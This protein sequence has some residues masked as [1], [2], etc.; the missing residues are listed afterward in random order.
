MESSS[1]EKPDW[2]EALKRFS[3][4]NAGRRTWL[5]IDDVRFG[6]QEQQHEYQLLGVSYDSKDD[7][8]QIMLGTFS[9]IGP[10]LTHT[11]GEVVEVD[12]L[13]DDIGR[14][15]I[16]RIAESGAQTLLRVEQFN[17]RRDDPSEGAHP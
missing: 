8:I 17:D 16:L 6:A 15:L 4:R 3:E 2:A 13:A 14:D 7:R 11:I 9:G 5:E 10:H 1:V 12:I